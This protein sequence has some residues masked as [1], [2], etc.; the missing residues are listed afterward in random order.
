MQRFE[1]GYSLIIASSSYGDTLMQQQRS[2]VLPS[3]G[4]RGSS[5]PL[6]A[7]STRPEAAF[8]RAHVTRDSGRYHCAAGFK[9]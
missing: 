9:P 2:R 6:K 5:G 1:D 4:A 3:A 8:V 7:V